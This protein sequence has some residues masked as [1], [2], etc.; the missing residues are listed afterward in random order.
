[1]RA[2]T[3]CGASARVR[4]NRRCGA[5]A[6]RCGRGRGRGGG[7]GGGLSESVGRGLLLSPLLATARPRPRPRPTSAERPAGRVVAVRGCPVQGR[8]SA[9]RRDR[10]EAVTA[11]SLLVFS[12]V[13]W[14]Q[15]A[16]CDLY[17]SQ[18]GEPA[19]SPFGR[20]H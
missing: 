16:R 12:S 4:L 7:T 19:C 10:D 8:D 6:G 5:A 11:S 14:S 1:M 9:A 15:P 18:C 17:L 20:Y 2:R 3:Q 13:S